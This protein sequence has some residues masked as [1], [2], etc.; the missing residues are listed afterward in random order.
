MQSKDDDQKRLTLKEQ[1]Y[2][3]A[4]ERKYSNEKIESLILFL[5]ELIKLPFDL[6]KK[7]TEYISKPTKSTDM[8]Y[9]SHK[10]AAIW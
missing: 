1:I 2:K 7:F 10:Q 8:P 4:K 3:I 9:I 5:S 6:E